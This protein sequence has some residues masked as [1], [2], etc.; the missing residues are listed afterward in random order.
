MVALGEKRH[1]V[2][3]EILTDN[4]AV[5]TELDAILCPLWL[6]VV[7]DV[8]LALHQMV[9]SLRADGVLLISV[10]G[11]ESFRE[12][13]AAW[14][15]IGEPHGH[16]IPLTD[17]R[18]VG[19]LLQKIKLALPVVDRDIITLTFPTFTA[20]YS[21][22][23]REGLRNVFTGRHQ[24]LLTPRKLQAMEQAYTQLFKRP[25]GRLPLTLEVIYAHGLRPSINQPTAAKRGSG[26]V[27]LVR[28]LGDK[29]QV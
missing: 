17:V 3:K 6:S 15:E 10:L 18:E 26:K 13:R 28:I 11:M 29:N 8:P 16:I 14:T 21:F 23:R 7:N 27:S 25:D 12:F 4:F 2:E 19:G 5:E 1:W 22:L 24:G 20:L 9:R